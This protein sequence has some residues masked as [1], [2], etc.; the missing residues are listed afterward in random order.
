MKSIVGMLVL[1]CMS[2]CAIE[3]ATLT[4][5]VGIQPISSGGDYVPVSGSPGEACS[6]KSVFIINTDHGIEIVEVPAFCN[7]SIGPDRGDPAPDYASDPWEN[8]LHGNVKPSLD[9]KR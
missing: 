4:D 3:P 2:G 6:A 7:R 9:M 5:K 1:A 8:V